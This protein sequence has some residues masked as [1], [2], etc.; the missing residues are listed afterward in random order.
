MSYSVVNENTTV[1]NGPSLTLTPALPPRPIHPIHLSI[2]L[3]LCPLLLYHSPS[4]PPSFT[5]SLYRAFPWDG[6]SSSF[7]TLVPRG[8]LILLPF[9]TH[10][11]D[12]LA[13][14]CISWHLHCTASTSLH[15]RVPRSF[16]A[17]SLTLD[18]HRLD[19][20]YFYKIWVFFS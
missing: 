3:I 9:L 4:L 18:L 1:V 20:G 11:L 15:A 10:P 13:E 12:S 6:E 8:F 19:R 14:P 17:A 7:F 16:T 2:R 5:V